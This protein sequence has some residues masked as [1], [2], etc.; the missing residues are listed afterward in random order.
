MATTSHKRP[1][2]AEDINASTS[3]KGE[4]ESSDLATEA[5]LQILLG[6]EQPGDDVEAED[7]LHVTDSEKLR[8]SIAPHF[9][10]AR[11]KRNTL[12][13]Y[14]PSEFQALDARD[15]IP[16]T[17]FSEPDGLQAY[18]KNLR[19]ELELILF[20]RALIYSDRTQAQDF[21]GTPGRKSRLLADIAANAQRATQEA[22]EILR[23][24][25]LNTSA[26]L[27]RPAFHWN[28]LDDMAS[29]TAETLKAPGLFLV[30]VRKKG[31]G[32]D[33]QLILKAYTG[34]GWSAEGAGLRLLTNYESAFRAAEEEE[35][36]SSSFKSKNLMPDFMDPHIQNRCMCGFSSTS[37]H[38]ASRLSS[39][40]FRQGPS[41]SVAKASSPTIAR[42]CA[43]PLLAG[44]SS[45]EL[46]ASI[47]AW[48]SATTRLSRLHTRSRGLGLTSCI[49]GARS[50][51]WPTA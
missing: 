19:R 1:A 24:M 5:D 9:T 50:S 51:T 4:Q 29:P 32:P 40:R 8:R 14:D 42:H 34:I 46:C 41:S 23:H 25:P 18:R 22:R 26:A 33:G 21:S 35:W 6:E 44:N 3:K 39:R 43:S 11:K 16:A 45:Y 13:R 2:T 38:K 30:I 28:D 15:S 47:S 17:R 12:D 7:H 20:K 37:L 31:L 36:I 49:R 48:C 27:G 10:P